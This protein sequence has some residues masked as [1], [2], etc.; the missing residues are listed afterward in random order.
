MNLAF[1]MYDLK[2]FGGKPARLDKFAR[3]PQFPSRNRE[4]AI[5][6]KNYTPLA[7]YLFFFFPVLI[8]SFFYLKSSETKC[9]S[10]SQSLMIKQYPPLLCPS[11]RRRL[12][13]CLCKKNNKKKQYGC[14]DRTRVGANSWKKRPLMKKASANQIPHKIVGTMS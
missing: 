6:H 4:T 7:F 13:C 14:A 10:S 2:V 5:H 11:K 8:C 12:A 3:K 1:Q 9:T